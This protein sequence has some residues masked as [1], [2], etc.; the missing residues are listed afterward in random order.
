MS[1][2]G[3]KKIR[4]VKTSTGLRQ[5]R[6]LSTVFFNAIKLLLELEGITKV[7]K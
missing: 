4:L 6:M 2:N 7:W 5:E 1:S 3:I